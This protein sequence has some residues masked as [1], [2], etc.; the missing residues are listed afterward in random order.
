MQT[1]NNPIGSPAKLNITTADVLGVLNRIIEVEGLE[2]ARVAF[3]QMNEFFS[4]MWG[5]VETTNAVY[6]LFAAVRRKEHKEQFEEQLAKER[7]GA[8]SFVWLNQNKNQNQNLSEAIG[9]K[10]V[11]QLNGVIE[12]GAEVT[13]T[14]ND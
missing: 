11:D 14:K 9:I 4:G 7:A 3:K 8:A 6:A 10:N 5:W 12:E 1:P 13:H 2:A